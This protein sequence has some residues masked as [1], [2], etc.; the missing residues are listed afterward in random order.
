MAYTQTDHD[1]ITTAIVALGKGKRRV[2][3]TTNG[4]SVT[5][6]QANLAELKDLRSE[7]ASEIASVAGTA[8]DFC[9]IQTG[10]GF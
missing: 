10:K 1:E 3:V 5:Y 7:I 4:K 2:T 9:Y 6:G 8:T